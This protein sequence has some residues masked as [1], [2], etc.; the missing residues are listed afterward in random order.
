MIRDRRLLLAIVPLL[1]LGCGGA[2]SSAVTTDPHHEDAGDAGAAP[3]SQSVDAARAPDAP[4]PDVSPISK[5]SPDAA[6]A[7]TNVVPMIV[8]AGP[9]G[10]DSF[11]APFISVTLCAPGTTSCLTIDEMSVDTGASGVRVLASALTGLT[12][13]QQTSS[14]GD[15]LVE[16]MTYDDG[17]SWGPVKLADVR[18]GGK[19]AA[20]IPIQVIGDPQFSTVPHACSDTGPSENTVVTFG[21]YGTVGINQIVPDEGDYYS[22]KGSSCAAVHVADGDQVPN[23]IASFETDNNGAVLQFPPVPA[24]GA[25]TLAGS[26]IFGI[27]TAANNALG[28][29]TVLTVNGNSEFTTVFNGTTMAQSYIDSNTSYFWFFDDSLTKCKASSKGGGYYCP[30]SPTTLSA[31]NVGKNGAMSNASFTVANASSL[32]SNASYTAFDDIG[33]P[34]PKASF[35]WG[36]PFFIGR[37]IF[38]ALD[39]A[40]TPAGNGPYVAY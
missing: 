15:P 24:D 12:L 2:G 27:G 34:G 7:P 36:F 33:G 9:P 20:R 17:Y 32:F 40:T 22:C 37:S 23:P 3:D 25:T 13:P 31:Q 39:G 6:G 1:G 4:F 35:A 38:V 28:A 10:A 21:S 29:A 30:E 8:N 11:D 14:D 26:L 5:G 18:I 19:L 16:C